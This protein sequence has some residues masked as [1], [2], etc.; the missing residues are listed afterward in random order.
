MLI[1]SLSP[2]KLKKSPISS[3]IPIGLLLLLGKGSV[4]AKRAP[5]APVPPVIHE[6]VRYK[7]GYEAPSRGSDRGRDQYGGYVKAWD[8]KSNKMLWAVQVYSVK[9]NPQIEGDVQDIFITSLSIQGNLL[10]VVNER[11][12]EFV[13]DLQTLE[14]E[15]VNPPT[16]VSRSWW[17]F[18]K[19]WWLQPHR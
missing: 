7:A 2:N 8:I 9:Y 3:L 18:W 1:L 16:P 17:Q 4:D 12:K 13:I 6:G 19:E 11:G 10:F 14:V 5:P 15:K